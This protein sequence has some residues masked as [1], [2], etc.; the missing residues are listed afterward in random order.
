MITVTKLETLTSDLDLR[1]DYK[2]YSLVVENFIHVGKAKNNQEF[3]KL[4]DV[5]HPR[6]RNFSYQPDMEY[7]GITTTNENFDEIG[8][9]VDFD[10]VTFDEHPDRLKYKV[11][12]DYLLLS[13]LKGAKCPPFL[14][15][16]EWEN[17]VFSN[18]FYI[19][20]IAEGNHPVFIKYLLQS[21]YFRSILDE[22]LYRGI[23]ISTFKE[24]DFLD[25]RIPKVSYETQKQ[26]VEQIRPIEHEIE[27][28]IKGKIKLVEVVNRVLG[29]KFGFDA[30]SLLSRK[31]TLV[32]QHGLAQNS[33]SFDLRS[34]HK[35]HNPAYFEVDNILHKLGCKK[36]KYSLAKDI[37]LG[38]GVSPSDIDQNASTYFISP[39]AMSKGYVSLSEAWVVSQD[40]FEKNKKRF[41]VKK[42]DILLRRSGMSIGKVAI[43][44]DEMDAVYSD[45]MMRVQFN[46]KLAYPKFVY[47]FFNS[48]LFQSLIERD[49][50]GLQLPNIF[51]SQI[52]N[53][54][55]PDISI[56]Q[57]IALAD[58]IQSEMDIQ[59]SSIKQILKKRKEI[60]KHVLDAIGIS[61]QG[62]W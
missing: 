7:K 49:K 19:Y 33:K 13:S 20:E 43:V 36:I 30:E 14:I 8:N 23:G 5:L 60:E 41:A 42:G 34:S 29:K 40:Y 62:N 39:A 27:P 45:F 38:A 44:Q 15:A 48:I 24:R 56:S 6:Y 17:A 50:K 61:K 53:F 54:P 37:R 2:Y 18:G 10:L 12:K 31:K 22:H 59:N 9:I 3:I 55:I 1:L 47:Y 21:S 4:K 16:D 35:F 57:Q 26:I 11:K 28:L 32:Y 52:K 46:P 51:P 25:I 58:E